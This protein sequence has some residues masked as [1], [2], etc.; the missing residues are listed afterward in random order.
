MLKE[1]KKIYYPY[2]TRWSALLDCPKLEGAPDAKRIF[3]CD[4]HRN[5]GV[6]L[7]MGLIIHGVLINIFVSFFYAKQ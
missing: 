6:L 4:S 5:W 7:N 2:S 1:R 3:V